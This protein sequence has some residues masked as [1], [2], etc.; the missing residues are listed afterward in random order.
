LLKICKIIGWLTKTEKRRFFLKFVVVVV[1]GGGRMRFYFLK[2][3]LDRFLGIFGL[4][5]VTTGSL[6]VGCCSLTTATGTSW[7]VLNFSEA[8][9]PLVIRLAGP[10]VPL[11][12]VPLL[13]VLVVVLVASKLMDP[14][15]ADLLKDRMKPEGRGGGAFNKGTGGSCDDSSPS[16][17]GGGDEVD[18]E[19]ESCFDFI[20]LGSNIKPS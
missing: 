12:L 6:V 1:V 20:V 18:E 5:G 2:N 15:D 14:S 7:D 11:A 19:D 16:A 8:D 10:L 4:C 17:T 13:L 3:V 9:L